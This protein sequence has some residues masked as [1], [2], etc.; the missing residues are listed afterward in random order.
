MYRI[1][2]HGRGG[3]GIK[4]ASRVIGSAFHHEGFEVQDAPVFGAE[5]RGA[6]MVC[7]LRASR[8]AILERG[9]ISNPDLVVVTDASL[10]PI[11]A[12]SVLLGLSPRTV[13]LIKT[14]RSA[15]EW[16]R[17]LN[18]PGPIVTVPTGARASIDRGVPYASMA[19]AGAATRLVGCI[20]RDALVKGIH[21]ELRGSPE[22][23]LSANLEHALAAYDARGTWAG[24]VSE[25]GE[26]SARD[27]ARPEWVNLPIEPAEFSAPDIRASVTSTNLDT[28]AWRTIRPVV[29]PDLCHGCTWIC[30]TLCPDSAIRVTSDYRPEIDYDHCKGCL[31]CVGVC[32]H[33]AIAPV[34]ETPLTRVPK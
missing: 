1:R 3:Q 15:D 21:D 7:Y 27:Y 19:C 31:V 11:P 33:H 28:G 22:A 32:P 18:L 26:I 8:S 13:L 23:V 5:R 34:P 30:S 25:G 16:G 9:I 4:T 17:R 29:D 20:T 24:I 14:P 12:A 6:P 2:V 10:I